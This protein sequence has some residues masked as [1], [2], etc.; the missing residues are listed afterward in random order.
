M[1]LVMLLLLLSAAFALCLT[2]R[3]EYRVEGCSQM[4]AAAKEGY[5]FVNG[6]LTV[7]VMRNCCS[8][9]LLVE[10]NGN[11]YRILEIEKTEKFADVT[12]CLRFTLKE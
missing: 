12:V 3:V 1:R 7:F 9:D 6:T 2:E 10:K 4:K 8:E 5:E 11:E